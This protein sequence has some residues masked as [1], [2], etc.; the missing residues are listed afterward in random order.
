MEDDFIFLKISVNERGPQYILQNGRRPKYYLYGRQP[1]LFFE[2]EDKIN[3]IS[4]EDDLRLITQ[5][6]QTPFFSK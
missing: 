5:G 3:F 1:Q 4:M 2:M 6:T